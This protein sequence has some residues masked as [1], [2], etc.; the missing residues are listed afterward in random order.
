MSQKSL[1]LQTVDLAQSN[2]QQIERTASYKTLSIFH[3][4]HKVPQVNKHD[5]DRLNTEI[6]NEKN[7]RLQLK[8]NATNLFFFLQI[9][10]I[11]YQ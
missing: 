6:Q 11:L 7:K 9:L 3:V 10:H 2:S 1:T 5:K 8:F 4:Q